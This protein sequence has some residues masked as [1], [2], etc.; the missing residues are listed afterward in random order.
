MAQSP[1]S[2]R[3]VVRGTT[4]AEI[5][6]PSVPA[7]LMSAMLLSCAPAAPPAP[8]A[9]FVLEEATIA[10]INAAFEAGAL[11][12]QQLV[13]LYL[14]RIAA[15]DNDGPMLNSII[16]VNPKALETAAALDAERASSGPGLTRHGEASNGSLTAVLSPLA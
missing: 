13:Q 15:Y 9:V 10:D 16:T 7:V 12:C 8:A 5:T 1:G 14:D 2:T 3:S 11:S 4:L 6:R